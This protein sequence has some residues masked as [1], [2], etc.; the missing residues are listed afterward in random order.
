MKTQSL[1]TVAITQPLIARSKIGVWVIFYEKL[2]EKLSFIG[3]G[4]AK[5]TVRTPICR[6]NPRLGGQTRPRSES[7]ES[8]ARVRP[9]AVGRG[10]DPEEEIFRT[11]ERPSV[12]SERPSERPSSRPTKPRGSKGDGILL[13]AWL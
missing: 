9:L 10:Q 2:Y 11:S 5:P 3:A 8:A 1:S 7:Y 13:V 6:V 4:Q 12:P